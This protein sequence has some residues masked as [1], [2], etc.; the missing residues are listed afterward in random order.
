MKMKKT[1]NTKL[2]LVM[3]FSIISLIAFSQ[4][5]ISLKYNL[6]KGDK[7]KYESESSQEISFVANDQTIVMDMIMGMY[8]TSI[9]DNVTDSIIDNTYVIDRI[10]LEQKIFGMEMKYDSDDSSTFSA[11]PGAQLAEEFGKM[12]GSSMSMRIDEYGNIKEMNLGNLIDNTDFT[13]D[14][15]SGNYYAVYPDYKVKV[16]D[17][18]EVEI[19]PLEDSDM[20]VFTKYTLIKAKKKEAIISFTGKVTSNDIKGQGLKMDGETKG[21]MIINPKTG[22]LKSSKTDINMKMDIEQN[23]VKFPATVM[24]TTTL[25][26]T[27]VK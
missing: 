11:G 10:K 15:K 13:Q 21:E 22:M 8:M 5:Q 2:S 3:L 9:V 12:I 25:T 24:G 14:F 6:D 7:Y 17:S 16:G 1:L 19:T 18:W 4:K 23:G 27:E 26:V 20:K